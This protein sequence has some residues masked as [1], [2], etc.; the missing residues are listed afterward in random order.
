MILY[1]LPSIIRAIELKR[2][3]WG[4]GA[5]HVRW[6]GEVPAGFDREP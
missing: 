3:R 5:Y 2:M 6:R 1:S 4:G